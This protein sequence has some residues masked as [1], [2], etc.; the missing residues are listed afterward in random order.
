MVATARQISVTTPPL[1]PKQRVV[2]D[3]STRF[4]VLSAGRRWGKSMLGVALCV[5]TAVKG[6]RAW[7]VAPSYPISAVGWREIKALARQ[8]PGVT[9]RESDRII[10]TPSGGSVQVRSADNPDSLRG[11]GLNFCVLDECAFMREE[12]WTEALRPA[13]SDRRGRALFISTPKGRNW[14]WRI[15]MRGQG[16]DAEWKSWQFPTASNPYIAGSEI[17]AARH[18]LPQRIF[19]QEY[20]ASFIDETGGV[21]RGVTDAATATAQTE[22]IKG[23]QYVAGVDW[24]KHADFTVIVVMDVNTK[25]MVAFD[26]FNQIDYTLQRARLRAL[27]ERFNPR[28]VIAEQNSIGDPIIEVLLREGLPMQPFVTTNATKAAAID[29]LALAFERGELRILPEPTLIA[30]LQAYEA[31]R[32]PSGMLRYSAPEGMHDDCVVSLALAWQGA[33]TEPAR[34]CISESP[35]Y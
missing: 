17:E 30:E 33:S 20:L 6:G 25:E 34:V 8:I 12:A 18:S 28:L 23:H 13:L 27:C 11:E 29:G 7:W 2:A 22:A 16:D 35:F 10:E 31:T 15:W 32:L 1:H 19:E 4:R 5:E 21:F 24:G 3:D 26:R 14:L 9:I